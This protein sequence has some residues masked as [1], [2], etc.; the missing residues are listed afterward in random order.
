M[1][2]E[3][4]GQCAPNNKDCILVASEPHPTR[5][6]ALDRHDN[7]G[8]GDDSS[9]DSNGNGDFHSVNSN[10]DIPSPG[11]PLKKSGGPPY[12]DLSGSSESGAM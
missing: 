12:L 3:L 11:P 9:D 4:I 5:S 8:G 7:G 1:K 2:P 10:E 6:V